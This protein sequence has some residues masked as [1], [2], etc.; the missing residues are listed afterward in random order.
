MRSASRNPA[1]VFVALCCIAIA[2]AAPAQQ[3]P[4]T[5][6]PGQLTWIYGNRPG[7][8]LL[9]QVSIPRRAPVPT[10]L[11]MGAVL[12]SGVKKLNLR[13][14]SSRFVAEWKSDEPS[15]AVMTSSLSPGVVIRSE[16]RGLDV[17]VGLTKR[18]YRP[19]PRM[20]F[21]AWA[22]GDAIVVKGAEG[23]VVV[24]KMSEPWLLAWRGPQEKLGDEPVLL[25]CQRPV[26][27]VTVTDDRWHVRFA[28]EA[29]SVVMMPLFGKF[30]RNTTDWR[31]GLPAGV[32]G[33]IRAWVKRLRR[34]PVAVKEMYSLEEGAVRFTQQFEYLD[35]DDYWKTPKRPWAML[36]PIFALSR[37]MGGPVRTGDKPMDLPWL[38]GFGPLTVLDDANSISFTI[39]VPRLRQYLW[40]ARRKP[41][42][43]VE[44][45]KFRILLARLRAEIDKVLKVDKHLAPF[46]FYNGN[47]PGIYYYWGNPAEAIVSL[48]GAL[49]FLRAD[50]AEA[51]KK[52]IAREY[53]AY[54]PMKMSFAPVPE[55][56]RREH[57]PWDAGRRVS[58]ARR[59][60]TAKNLGNLYAV[61]EYV[62]KVAGKDAAAA[63]WPEVKSYLSDDIH[64]HPCAWAGGEATHTIRYPGG[65]FPNLNARL[66]GYIGYARLARLVGDK[67][68]EKLGTCLLARGLAVKHALACYHQFAIDAGG[69]AAMKDTFNLHV[70]ATRRPE[71]GLSGH[72]PRNFFTSAGRFRGTEFGVFNKEGTGLEFGESYGLYGS[73]VAYLFFIDLTPEI[74]QFLHDHCRDA[75]RTVVG[76]VN[77]RYPGHWLSKSGRVWHH[78]EEQY[79]QP[80]NSWAA[81]LA[82]AL[83]VQEPPG[84]LAWIV[85]DSPAKVGD[86]YYI[87]KLSLALRAF[88]MERRSQ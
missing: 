50:R 53:R 87:Q 86:L 80:W 7:R 55:G 9:W 88:A 54:P 47:R 1:P 83:A 48:T 33:Q 36:P 6:A 23:K 52:Y 24:G 34:V 25:I 71:T 51:L 38:A 66:N 19:D 32:V 39:E 49:P 46:V 4:E 14:D 61:W 2:G 63:I 21:L 79:V 65:A 45:P 68:A 70:G 27:S 31:Q 37:A 81:F 59:S 58:K 29:G 67:E 5:P 57:Y 12:P 62:D 16:T 82:R 72:F 69:R 74:G 41:S 18:K 84:E 73:R 11:G 56:V 85:G 77:W 40:P 13:R 10:I 17:F 44:D 43:D 42:A 76:Y 28:G 78:S 64:E 60:D 26:S 8:T 35:I 75:V 22:S 3:R 15:F 20:K 30:G